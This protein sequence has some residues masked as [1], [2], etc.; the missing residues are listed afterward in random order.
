M[1]LPS[2]VLEDKLA[3]WENTHLVTSEPRSSRKGGEANSQIT[4]TGIEVQVDSLARRA[5]LDRTE[6][7]AVISLSEATKIVSY[8]FDQLGLRKIEQLLEIGLPVVE[9]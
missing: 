8:D 9:N 7:L 5:N 1:R 2:F 4:R 3:S 6:P